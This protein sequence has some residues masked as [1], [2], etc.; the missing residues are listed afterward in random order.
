MNIELEKAYELMGKTNEET[1]KP[2]LEKIYNSKIKKTNKTYAVSDFLGNNFSGELKSRTISI[3][4]FPTIMIGYN[5][6]KEGFR[7]LLIDNKYYFWFAL[8][9]GLYVWEVN[10]E[11]YDLNGGDSM[12]K[13]GGTNRRGYDDYK[14]HY[15]INTSNLKKIDDTIPF[16]PDIVENNSYK[17]SSIPRGVCWI[18][19]LGETPSKTP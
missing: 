15:Y 7:K 18:K 3:N 9:E 4:D 5:K 19:L 6:V 14:D 16:I 13:Y 2:I 12:I 10:K 8:R 1:Y 11:N 17:Q